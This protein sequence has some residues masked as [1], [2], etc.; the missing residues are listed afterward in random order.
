MDNNGQLIN[1]IV[2][3]LKR[4]VPEASIRST[5]LQNGWPTEPVDRAFGILRQNI[6]TTPGAASLPGNLPEVQQQATQQPVTR[7]VE[8][9]A[10]KPKTTPINKPKRSYRKPLLIALV[11]LLLIGGGV[12]AYL[13]L[14]KPLSPEARDAKRKETLT[15]LSN[16]LTMYYS[17]QGTYPTREQINSADFASFEDGFATD[18][19]YDPAWNDQNKACAT[20]NGKHIFADARTE[21]CFTY[22]AT[23]RN[24][25]ECKGSDDTP[26]SRVVITATL[27]SGDPY[28]ITLD[29]NDK[30]EY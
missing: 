25:S 11:A 12:G 4:G 13:Y 27:E 7:P 29:Q 9:P 3:E 18:K 24:G 17:S 19:F 6:P 2:Q 16:E 5:L 1:Y 30:K 26:C 28:I 10:S 14:T 22:R 23:A 8:L 21:N 15:S 20:D